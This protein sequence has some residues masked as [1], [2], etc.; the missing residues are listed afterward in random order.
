MVFRVCK[1]AGY[2]DVQV[3]GKRFSRLKH[4]GKYMYHVT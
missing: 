3:F 4:T 2:L 1:L